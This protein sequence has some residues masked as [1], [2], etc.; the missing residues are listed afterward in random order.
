[1]IERI[2][3]HLLSAH[4]DNQ[5]YLDY[6]A[7]ER[8]ASDFFT[9]APQDFEA[10][11]AA[12]RT[13]SY[14]RA[15]L[16]ACLRDYNAAI[17]AP[18][19]VL[20]HIEALADPD[21]FCVIAGQQ[22]GFL[23]GPA[24]TAYKIATTV[25][26]AAYLE[27]RLDARFVPLFWLASEDHDFGEINHAYLP[28]PDGEVGQVSFDWPGARRPIS[29]LPLTD[30]VRQAYEEYFQ[31]MPPGPFQEQAR[32]TFAPATDEDYC[33]WIARVWSQLFAK[34][35][36]VIVEPSVL[37]SLAGEFFRRVLRLEDQI[38]LRLDDVAQRLEAAGYRAALSS[39]QAGQPYTF[40]AQGYRV[41]VEH[42]Q[43]HLDQATAHPRRYSTDAALRPLFADQI[44][45]TVTSV[46]GPGEV[47]YHAML[48]PLYELFDL[49]QP[50][51]FPRKSYTVLPAAQA[52]R[53]ARYDVDARAVLKDGLDIGEVFLDLAPADGR[54][55][56]ERARQDSAQALEPLR[57]YVE[58]IDPSLVKTWEQTLYYSQSNLDDLEE[59]A[60]KAHM[61]QRGLSKGE[62]R[63]L[64]NILLPRGRLQ[65]R[66]FPLPY[67]INTFG[68]GFVERILDRGELTGFSHVV[69]TM[70]VNDD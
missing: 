70:E 45:P 17:E 55:L 62:L 39:D 10:A 61:S 13:A 36:L 18:G 14:P 27:N 48:R 65:E 29:D 51:L 43:R 20:E 42:P 60:M 4:L 16:V 54:V 67:F 49:S 56:F 32:E 9:H 3:P 40:D 68:L 63:A 8:S 47:A 58:A 69:L 34:H 31:R 25:R 46:L 12:R 28:Q 22:A 30:Q 52:E 2:D 7:A 11:L 35:G 38:R 59:R 33:A 57:P 66:V 5:I 26:L 19:R 23:G 50:L 24:Y 41:R 6:V 53:L 64:R 21:T 44:L 1:M 15:D 37:R